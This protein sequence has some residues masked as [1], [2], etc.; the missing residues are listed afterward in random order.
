MRT[1]FIVVVAALAGTALGAGMAYNQFTP[2]PPGGLEIALADSGP[3]EQREMHPRILIDDATTFNF[4]VMDR[5]Q[6]GQHTFEIK[7]IGAAPLTVEMLNKTCKCTNVEVDPTTPVAP[8]DICRVVVHWRAESYTAEY[9]HGATL[10]TN[11]PSNPM[12]ELTVEGRVQP[13]IRAEPM[14]VA[15]TNVLVHETRKASFIVFAYRDENLQ[16][17]DHHWLNLENDRN[18]D[19]EIHPLDPEI[20]K[21]EPGAL[22]GV[23]VDVTLK[24]G[25]PLGQFHQDLQLVTNAS[26]VAELSL[27]ISGNIVGDIT[28]SGR[29]L[30][31]EKNLLKWGG[32]PS[33][34]GGT[35]VVNAL[36][37]GPHRDEINL[38]VVEVFPENTLQVTVEE[39]RMVGSVK[40]VPIKITVPAGAETINCYGNDDASPM[41]RIVLAT[42]HPDMDRLQLD[43]RFA[44]TK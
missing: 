7:N 41:G 12:I 16:V 38:S 37:K 14:S 19:L 33:G 6:E 29:N 13:N 17:L 42:G 1:I 31:G 2:I 43:V 24:P 18:F 34:E 3:V 28:L 15:M 36:I 26:G 35:T 4:G 11:D 8:G 40:M 23:Q 27:F 30:I 22:S 9:R 32:I 21:S 5:G 39:A 44:V 10:G 20:V 25:L